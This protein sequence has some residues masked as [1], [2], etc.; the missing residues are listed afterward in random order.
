[1]VTEKSNLFRQK[2]LERSASPERLDRLVQVVSPKHWLP[3]TAL[4]TLVAA[5]LSW[6]IMGRVPIAVSGQGVLVY[7]SKVVSFQSSS[8]GQLQTVNVQVGDYVKKGQVLATIDKSDI[9]KQLQQQRDKL[10][11][12]QAQDRDAKLLQYQRTQLAKV[13]IA[14]QRQGIWQNLRVTQELSPILRDKG[15]LALEQQRLDLRQRLRDSQALAPT[16]KERL[17]R[18]K[19]LQNEGAISQDTV[20]EAQ[21]TYLDSLA[22]IADIKSQLKALDVRQVEAETSYRQNLNQIVS[23]QA[24][25]K[26]LDTQE[27]TLAEQ[28]FQASINR[29]NQILETKR[30]IGQLELQ[31]KGSQI[32]SKYSGRILEMAAAPGQVLSEGTRLGSI[33]AEAPSAKLVGV[34]FL[35][36]SEGKKIQKGMKM[37]ITPTTVQRER[38]GGIVGTVTNVSAFP[39]T[40]DGA[41]SLVGNPDLVQSLMSQGPQIQVFAE[42][43]PDKSTFSGYQWSSSKGPQVKI[44]AGTTTAVRVTVEERA[45]ITFVLPILRSWS[46]ID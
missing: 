40:K 7:P 23:L 2:A 10:V 45:P 3:L 27:K 22:R 36:V 19:W 4:G 1:M 42:L 46:G 9:K 6:S 29:Q 24:Q 33:A 44:S 35:P 17:E 11:E 39:V 30:I 28:D 32:T 41:L 14:Q 15:L 31:A 5:G 25:L 38:Y 16:L 20:L 43:Q 34:A 26:D 13:A 21:Q 18:R 8:S 37:Q 12:L